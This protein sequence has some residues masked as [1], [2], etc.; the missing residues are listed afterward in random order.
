MPKWRCIKCGRTYSSSVKIC[1]CGQHANSSDKNKNIKK[2]KSWTKGNTQRDVKSLKKQQQ[3]KS[4]KQDKLDEIKKSIQSKKRKLLKNNDSFYVPPDIKKL[5]AVCEERQGKEN[6]NEDRYQIDQEKEKR[7]KYK[8][9]EIIDENHY[10]DL[11]YIY[12]SESLENQINGNLKADDN[13][14]D[15]I[16]RSVGSFN[17]ISSL[18]PDFSKR[19][20]HFLY[21]RAKREQVD[22]ISPWGILGMFE[23]LTGIR[24]DIAWAD[25]NFRR[26]EEGRRHFSWK[27][28]N[29]EKSAMIKRPYFT[30][31]LMLVCTIV[32]I[33]SMKLNNWKFESLKINP[34]L[35]PSAE[36]LVYLGAKN[37]NMIVNEG[38]VWRIFTPMF[39]H[40]G[41]FHY[42]LN[43]LALRAIG[44]AVEQAHGC[45][46]AA[47]IFCV[48]GIGGTLLSCLF[49]P[50][51]IS[52]GASGGIF[53]FIGACLADI[54]MN[55][56]ILFSRE[57][58]K[59]AKFVDHLLM[60]FWLL[61][62]ISINCFIGFTPF[63]DNFN[64]M[65]GMIYGLIC[66][67]ALMGK[68]SMSFKTAEHKIRRKLSKKIACSFVIASLLLTTTIFVFQ[69]DGMTSPCHMCK[70]AS[71]VS[72]PPWKDYD[73]KWW[74]CDA[75][76]NSTADVSIRNDDEHYYS[77]M[78][79]NC[80]DGAK[81]DIDL[82]IYSVNDI[83]WLEKQLP[84]F[85][86][87]YCEEINF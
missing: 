20:R 37:T 53:G 87:D 26:E 46:A 27:K 31:F 42:A 24:L 2:E 11:N 38:Q 85:C 75:C 16:L 9:F 35:G 29:A 66:G 79:L 82:S 12:S 63:V 59:A 60:V 28:Y 72:F 51:F 71:C 39:L 43:M 62:D 3:Q 7:E 49:L 65:G 67:F 77:S 41:V 44:F 32:L 76:G 6:N 13:Y 64:H 4:L 50:E 84:S 25:E 21:A 45:F 56:K 14:L 55:W 86:R 52:V 81:E 19:L 30:Y 70:V 36:V 83:S 48:P 58:N 47:I 78:T 18:K 61:L 1:Y 23:F 17:N 69:G 54:I 73:S 74:Y 68:I 57:V 80:P 10:Y 8:P 15:R 34:M 40:A 22:G 5:L 33:Y